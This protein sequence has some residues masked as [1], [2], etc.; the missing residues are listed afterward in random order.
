MNEVLILLAAYNG[1]PWLIG[2]VRSILAQKDVSFCL[3]IGDDCSVDGSINELEIEISDERVY[4]TRFS[5]SSGGAGQ[6]FL[7]ILSCADMDSFEYI[8]FSDQDD[9]W[10]PEKLS[11]AI[12]NLNAFDADGY[13]SAVT[14]F[15]PDG[16]EKLLV[17]SANLTDL[18]FLFEGAGQGCTFVLRRDFAKQ[19]QQFVRSNA[20]LLS[21]IHYHDWLIYASSRVLG[22]QWVFDPEPTMR[23]R[24]HDGNDTGAR[25]VLGGMRKR[26]ILIKSGWYANQ[27]RQIMAAVSVLDSRGN[28]IPEDF[29]GIW[30]R[31][32]G[33]SRRF[34]LAILLLKRGRRRTFDRIVL[35]ASSLLGWL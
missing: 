9:Y 22:K 10:R 15:W 4:V 3:S 27:V 25:G 17:Q 32:R 30:N 6:N 13:S 35:A 5:V 34:L 18:D 29:L 26:L 12:S 2:Q 16:K 14:A 33:I 1:N 8:A 19:I 20:A 7:R 31:P 21:N 28:A 24:Q 11:R 23:Y